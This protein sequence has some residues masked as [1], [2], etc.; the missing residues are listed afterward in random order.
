LGDA[1]D[2]EV[3]VHAFIFDEHGM[4]VEGV[5]Y[6]A[7]SLSGEGIIN[8]QAVKC[9]SAEYM[10]SFISPWLYKLRD[11]DFQDVAALCNRLG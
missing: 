7:G 6:P 10:V 1:K 3:D 2:H 4:V 11:K 5:M 9:I 8:G